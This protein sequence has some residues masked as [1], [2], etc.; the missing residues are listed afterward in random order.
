M[1]FAINC[2]MNPKNSTG[3]N[4]QNVMNIA[5]LTILGRVLNFSSLLS[6]HLSVRKI[7]MKAIT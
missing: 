4:T 3:E 5:N 1:G 7:M 6:S 2:T